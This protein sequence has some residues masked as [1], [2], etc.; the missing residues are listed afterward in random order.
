MSSHEPN[1]SGLCRCAGARWPHRFLRGLHH[2]ASKRVPEMGY[3]GEASR[4][5]KDPH[6]EGNAHAF[7]KAG[8]RNSAR[9]PEAPKG[10]KLIACRATMSMRKRK[11]KIERFM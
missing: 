10:V 5:E 7:G 9:E 3:R 6:R 11:I 4:G 1:P 8:R 2:P